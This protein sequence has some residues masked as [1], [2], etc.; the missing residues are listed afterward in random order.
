MGMAQANSDLSSQATSATSGPA[1]SD[2]LASLFKMS[3]TAGL[4]SQDY[5]AVN[6]LSVVTLALGLASGLVLLDN[7]LLVIPIAGIVIGVLSL[8]Q[9]RKSAGTQTGTAWATLGL[10][11]CLGLA[12]YKFGNGAIA[13]ANSHADQSAL[14]QMITDLGRDV[15]QAD[16]T[17]KAYA[18]FSDDFRTRVTPEVFKT[19]W[20]MM[21]SRE[22][23]GDLTTIESN[24]IYRIDTD[25]KTK[26]TRG[27][28]GTIFAY[29][30]IST[31]GERRNFFFIK[32]P[33][34][35]KLDNIPDL[36]PSTTNLA[37]GQDPD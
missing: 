24:G 35:W 22:L 5:V 14:S 26:E 9:I 6:V 30:K 12:G 25:P 8:I 21:R 11:L 16:T 13:A 32:T 36:F 20:A 33:N 28:T 7:I 15:S 27:V 2:P 19:R 18:L 31:G 17:E 23:L 4:G 10:L 3:T 1:G 37:P 29:S 34:G